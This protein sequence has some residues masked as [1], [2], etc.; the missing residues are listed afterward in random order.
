[1]GG[2]GQTEGAGGELID[3]KGNTDKIGLKKND[4]V[5]RRRLRSG[6]RNKVRN[7]LAGRNHCSKELGSRQVWADQRD[8]ASS[9]RMKTLGGNLSNL[10]LPLSKEAENQLW[11]QE[12]DWTQTSRE[13]SL[14][15]KE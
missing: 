11:E 7:Y 10:T 5:R 9:T 13:N 15:Q 4:V 6:S 12:R 8:W 14:L 2:N 1:M 3:L